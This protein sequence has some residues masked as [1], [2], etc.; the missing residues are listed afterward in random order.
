MSLYG[1]LFAGVSG[2]TAQGTAIGVI[3]NNIANINTTG[4]KAGDVNFTSL[5]TDS[6]AGTGGGAI[7]SNRPLIEAQGLIQSTGVATDVAIQ[8]NGFLTVKDVSETGEGGFFY[9]RAG[10]FRQ[11]S[12]GNFVNAAGYYLQAWPLDSQGRLPGA[13]GNLNTTPS[14]LLTSLV[15]VNTRDISGVAFATSNISIGANLNAGQATLQGAGD[16]IDFATGEAANQGIGSDTII[17][18]DVALTGSDLTRG[19]ILNITPG[20]TAAYDFEYGGFAQ[21]VDITTVNAG[22]GI[23]GANTPS[24][25]FTGASAGDGFSITTATIGTLS[26]T[27][28]QSNP[29][30]DLRTFNSLNTLADAID[31]V[32]GLTARVSSNRLYVAPDDAN[33]AMTFVNVQGTL[34]AGL[35]TGGVFANTASDTNRF[36]TLNGL[37]ALI[38]D[39]DGISATLTSPATDARLAINVDNPLDTIDFNTGAGSTGNV[40]TAFGLASAAFSPVYDSAGVAGDNMASGVISAHFSRSVRVFDAQGN[41]H[42]VL[43]TFIKS[44]NNRWEV[45][46]FSAEPDEVVVNNDFGQLA[47][48]T[49]EFNGDGTL[50]NVDS[51]LSSAIEIVW[52]NGASPS[53]ISFNFGTA[54][55]EAG[56]EGATVIGLADGLSQF[57]G[58]FQ[59]Q[60]VEQDGASSGSLTSVEIDE[61]GFVVANFSNGQSRNVFTIPLASFPNANGLTARPGNTFSQ[62][63]ASGEFT[64]SST[65]DAGVGVFSVAAL[66][67]ANVELADE[68]TRIIIAQRSYQAATKVITTVDELLEELN[69][70]I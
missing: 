26:F 19:D 37:K 59:V 11:D 16:S 58:A 2:L 60:F 28:N 21:S 5:V 50:R 1:S 4:Y 34:L 63:D 57:S 61:D 39:S 52:S 54:G 45:E 29:N 66:E 55:V 53:E 44:G 10:S 25:V 6:E 33:E 12:R 56:T 65:G 51:T 24:E 43:M 48:G 14:Q 22:A 38:D 23:L 18:P 47:S 67:N 35:Q 20:L 70:S 62:S 68:L 41:G 69:R 42:D 30:A 49:I 7:A 46:I 40:L 17:V 32:T 64:L 13:P 15:T 8:G 9:T 36:S 27:F 31:N 3:S